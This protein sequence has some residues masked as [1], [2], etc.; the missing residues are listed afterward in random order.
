MQTGTSPLPA[1]TPASGP[2][3]RAEHNEF[4][5][6][7]QYPGVEWVFH[8]SRCLGPQ[9]FTW[10]CPP[11]S[12]PGPHQILCRSAGKSDP[13]QPATPVPA[14]AARWHLCL[15]SP[16]PTSGC[17]FLGPVE[18][19]SLDVLAQPGNEVK[20]LLFMCLHVHVC[21]CVWTLTSRQPSGYFLALCACSKRKDAR[22]TRPDAAWGVWVA[23]SLACTTPGL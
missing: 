1:L 8:D 14:F 20:F 13:P 10:V 16:L 7:T 18:A 4:T 11:L 15:S 6:Q 3:A 19:P 23:L 5:R 17:S 2:E 21:A 9:W 12:I 22:E